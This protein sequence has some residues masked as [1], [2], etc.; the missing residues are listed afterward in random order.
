MFRNVAITVAAIFL[1]CMLS[2][3]Q[4]SRFLNRLDVSLNAAGVISKQSAGNGISLSPTQG[5][6][7]FGSLRFKLAARS[8]L[9]VTIGRAKNSQLFDAPPLQYRIQGPV[10]E[11]TGAYVF[12]LRKRG[13]FEPFFL[14]GAGVLVFSPNTTKVFNVVADTGA[15]RETRPTFLYGGG[16]DYQL[17]SHI[18]IRAQYRG[19]FYRAPDYH[20]GNLV[21]GSNGHLA[22]PSL[23]VVFKF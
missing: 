14:G 6:G 12:R 3:A 13:K 2:Q 5:G 8:S 22:E 7:F 9:E 21:T 10:T 18:A 11:V 15:T 23:G 17:R 20:L 4:K 1:F 19:L 16:I